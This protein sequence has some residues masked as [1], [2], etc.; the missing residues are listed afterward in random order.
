MDA[1]EL[2]AEIGTS[3]M[4]FIA[5]VVLHNATVA[6]RMGLGP[7][8]SQFV[9]LLNIHGALTPGRLAELS[10]LTTGTVTGVI[11]R[12]EKAGFVRRERDTG[13]RRKVLVDLVPEGMA[14][15]AEQ[16]REHGEHLAAVLARRD[17]GQLQV[18]ADFFAEITGDG[19]GQAR[20]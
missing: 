1:D 11:D 14:R 2:R 8:D 12:L 4:R 18:L 19:G 20:S 5:D 7:S 9:S 17:A 15:M 3:V 16:Y 10:G 13:D 6:Q